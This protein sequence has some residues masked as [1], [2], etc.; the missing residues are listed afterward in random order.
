MHR[1]DAAGQLLDTWLQPRPN[2][3]DSDC[4]TT[5]SRPYL[6][7][8]VGPVEV[9]RIANDV[10]WSRQDGIPHSGRCGV[11][12]AHLHEV[13]LTFANTVH[14]LNACQSDRDAPEAFE[15]K[16]DVPSG[17]RP[18]NRSSIQ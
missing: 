7:Q 9:F 5:G 18:A 8:I 14:Q 13:E 2:A 4:L 12:E 6:V 3:R 1:T 15:A 16:H 11:F 10:L 17:W